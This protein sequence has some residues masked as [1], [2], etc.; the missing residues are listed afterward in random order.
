MIAI[1]LGRFQKRG[2]NLDVFLAVASSTSIAA[3]ALW[4]KF[5]MVWAGVIALSQV[6]TVVKPY[7]PFRKYATEFT[8]KCAKVELLNIEYERLWDKMQ[9]GTISEEDA[10]ETYY[11]LQRQVSEVMMFGED[12]IFEV[13][14][15]VEQEATQ[16]V[17]IFLK[18][19]YQ[20]SILKESNSN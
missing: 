14:K 9:L 8:S 19:N 17:A 12:T 7:Y 20:V 2:R 10:S 11:S 16:R 13:P 18:A 6:L 3:W 4:Q 5:Q 15:S 1:M